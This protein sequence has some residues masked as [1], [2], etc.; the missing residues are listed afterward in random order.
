MNSKEEIQQNNE[1][2]LSYPIDD[3]VAE[4]FGRYAKYII[5]ERAL[6]DVR[7]GLKPVQRRIL[8]AMNDLGLTNDKAY[9]KAARVVGEVIGKYHP[10]GDTAVYA[11]MCRMAQEWKVA[12]PLVQM[13]GNKG[14]IDGD[15]PAAMRY[16]EARLSL[17]SELLLKD[18]KKNTIS[19]IKNFDESETEP[20]VL[21]A[22]FPNLLVN[23]AS[24][25]AVGMAT[26]IP[27]HNL[28]EVINAIVMRINNPQCNLSELMRVIKGPDFPTGGII[29][30]I[31]G[32]K[33]AYRSGKGR[34]AIR[35]KTHINNEGEIPQ[36]IIT[37]IPFEVIKQDL[38]KKIDDVK[39]L[40]KIHGIKEV[41]DETD[42]FGLRIVIDLVEDSK[43][44]EILNYLFKN[45]NLQIYYNFNLVA[46]ANKKPVQMSLINMLDFYINH[47]IDVVTKRSQYDLAQLERRLEIVNGLVIAL[48][49]VDKVIKIIRTSTDRMQAKLNLISAFNFTDIQ[50]EAIVQ[51]RLYRLTATDIQSLVLEKADIE[52][53]I[54]VLQ[55]ILNNENSLRQVIITELEQINSHFSG[56][57]KSQIQGEISE[58]TIDEKATLRQENVFV[59]ISYDGW[60]K[61]IS[62]KV[63]LQNLDNQDFGRKPN[64]VIIGG[65][66]FNNF[67]NL[68]FF[69]NKGNYFLIPI[70]KLEENKWKDNG[71]HVNTLCKLE[72]NEKIISVAQVNSFEQPN[73]NIVVATRYGLIKRIPLL[74]LATTRFNKTAKYVKLKENDSVISVNSTTGHDFIVIS[75]RK[76]MTLKYLETKVPLLTKTATGVKALKI[77]SEEDEVVGMACGNSN[78]IYAMLT[79]VGTIKRMLFNTIEQTS[80]TT[81]GNKVIKVPKSKSISIIK[82]FLSPA[83]SFINILTKKEKWLVIKASDINLSKVN[84]GTG[85]VVADDIIAGGNNLVIDLKT[86]VIDADISSI[87]ENFNTKESNNGI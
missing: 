85:K 40:A 9:K 61:V 3:I 70:F 66:M 51:L 26:N 15:N 83:T 86:D 71:I 43:P 42:R 12:W 50:A 28:Q 46:I 73:V 80:R 64:D 48:S 47:Q 52:S 2:I 82:T 58:I 39:T 25:I 35:A 45:T 13:H 22:Y 5:L 10:H 78:D 38:I 24:G 18:I 76:G 87:S 36:I 32:I 74:E 65:A 8:H 6:P 21:P 19:L 33:E 72:G 1:Q 17:I 31:K 79:S 20:T 75:T 23:G 56:L 63:F 68:L 34:I 11:A 62:S 41:R 7:D 81:K 55:E 44:Q 53:K 4:R 29:Q 27:P 59:S 37:E 77:N 30:G 49:E 54:I 57:R 60:I 69:T 67:N 84:E 14:S 16:T